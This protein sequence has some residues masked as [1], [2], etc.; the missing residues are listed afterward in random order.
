V[1]KLSLAKSYESLNKKADSWTSHNNLG[2]IYL[3]KAKAAIGSDKKDLLDK[4]ITQLTIANNNNAN[5]YSYLNLA[6]AQMLKGDKAGVSTSL[7]KAN[8]LLSGL[9]AGS[10]EIATKI[11][12]IQGVLDIK[13]GKYD[14]AISNLEPINDDAA[15]L[16]NTGLAK[17]LKKDIEGAKSKLGA[18]LA[19]DDKM[20]LSYYLLAVANAR[21]E[22]DKA[23]I[24]NMKKAVALDSK[25]KSRAVT[26]MEFAKLFAN[27]DFLAAIK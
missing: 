5:P 14:Q 2:A 17:L 22:N 1:P 11:K 24:E 9:G 4:A 27:S 12:G 10:N 8:S 16:Y 15:A 18:S 20:A 6:S 21:K 26:D 23:V 25:L 7:V 19:K 3:E 13:N